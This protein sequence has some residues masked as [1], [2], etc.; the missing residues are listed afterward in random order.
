MEFLIGLLWPVGAGAAA[1]WFSGK[2]RGRNA[3]TAF[4]FLA[5]GFWLLLFPLIPLPFPFNFW[6]IKMIP[7]A[8]SFLLAGNSIL[9]EMRAQQRG[10]YTDA[11]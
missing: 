2:C 1:W 5:W 4:R 10:E 7:S 3:R 8:V 6:I 11:A 9:K